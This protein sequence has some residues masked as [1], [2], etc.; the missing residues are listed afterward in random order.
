MI[1]LIHRRRVI[2]ILSIIK[3]IKFQII[4]SI[5]LSFIM[6]HIQIIKELLI[7]SRKK[8]LQGLCLHALFQIQEIYKFFNSWLII[9]INKILIIIL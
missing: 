8:N 1:C 2:N 5:L 4:N 7:K 6:I 3:T 9:K